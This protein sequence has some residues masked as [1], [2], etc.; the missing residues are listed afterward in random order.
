MPRMQL[1]EHFTIKKTEKVKIKQSRV[2]YYI[3]IIMM[4]HV[5]TVNILDEYDLEDDI[6]NKPSP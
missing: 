6:W 5:E 2:T 1:N 3:Q 4:T